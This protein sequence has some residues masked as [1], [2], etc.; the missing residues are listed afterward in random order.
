MRRVKISTSFEVETDLTDEEFAYYWNYLLGDLSELI[1]G[2]EPEKHF[3]RKSNFLTN[4]ETIE[5]DM[6]VAQDHKESNSD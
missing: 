3:S 1:T 5:R 4:C 2:C 6:I